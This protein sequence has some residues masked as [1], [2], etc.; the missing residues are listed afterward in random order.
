MKFLKSFILFA[1]FMICFNLLAFGSDQIFTESNIND[2]SAW[3]VLNNSAASVGTITGNFI[4]TSSKNI[5][6]DNITLRADTGWR[7]IISSD[8]GRFFTVSGGNSLTLDNLIFTRGIYD[9]SNLDGGGA[10]SSTGT[11]I[12]LNGNFSIEFASSSFLG[13]AIYVQYGTTTFN[14][15]SNF[16][17]NYAVSGHGGAIYSGGNVIFS[18]GS[19]VNLNDNY[20]GWNGGGIYSELG[21]VTVGGAAN[22][23]GNTAK[24]GRGG[25]IFSENGAYFTDSNATIYI[26]S[27]AAQDFGGGIYSGKDILFL[28]GA[29]IKLNNAMI[30]SSTNT[31]H[32]GG[33]LY[34]ASSVTFKNDTAVINLQNNSA[35]DS[36]GAIFSYSTIT[37]FGSA[38]IQSNKVEALSG[39][40]IWAGGDIIFNNSSATATISSNMSVEGSG[41]AFYCENDIVFNG[42]L[43][44][45]GNS[46]S[47]GSGGAFYS[48]TLMISDGAEISNNSA[49]I[50]GGAIYIYDGVS[51]FNALEKDILFTSNIAAS[52]KNDINLGGNA[53]LNLTALAAA[54]TFNG[55]ITYSTTT[56]NNVVN[57]YG[58]GTL[59][60]NGINNFQHLN[61]TSGTTI[62]GGG[63]VFE[64]VNFSLTGSDHF[65]ST[66]ATTVL[67]MRNNNL[68]DNLIIS[69]VLNSTTGAKIYFDIDS[70]TNASDKISAAQAN[71]EGTWIKV[72]I[73]G[74]DAYEKSYNIFYSTNASGTM[75]ID[76][77]N[78]EGKTMHRVNSHLEYFD[79]VVPSTT[80]PASWESVNLVLSIDQLNVINGLTKN[81]KKT[82]LALDKEYGM[83][84]GDLFDII[85]K[86]DTLPD[87]E[88]KKKALTSLS[89]HIFA[90]VITVP[91][92]NISKDGVFSRL[93]RSY[94]I[95]DDSLIK[96]NI[97]AQGY[98]ADN[99]YKGD[100][101]SPGDFSVSNSG[102]QA[103]FDTMKDDTQIFGLNVGYTDMNAQQNGDTVGITGYNIGAYGAFFFENNFELKLVLIGGRQ[104]YSASRKINYADIQRRADSEFSGYSINMSAELGY[105][106]FYRDN[107]YFR[108]LLGLD[109]SYV[110]TQEFTEQGAN[111]A[112]LTIY[113]GSYSKMNSS[114]GLQVNNGIDMRAKWYVE[115]K[116]NFL[117]AGTR[118]AFEGEF[119]NTSQPLEIVGIENDILSM[120]VSAGVLYDI[121]KNWS[122]YA[123]VNG[124]FVSSQSGVYG[125][126][127]VNYKFTT[128]YFDFYEK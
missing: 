26:S 55:G 88:S 1:F 35:R 96:R 54:I 36:G 44:A 99:K 75:R 12:I 119:K 4:F 40:A 101:N 86:L 124:M 59:F 15:S 34:A 102:M 31:F 82:A 118:A 17:M 110:T 9:G 60:L 63:S 41:G 42:Y 78:S 69:G 61:I 126:I 117:L 84:L 100:K 116:F 50:Q 64:A 72:G 74:I 25:G 33:G 28:G 7:T 91:S 70:N 5:T 90:N 76:N 19:S 120:T 38:N 71:M 92:L 58:Y 89:G 57:K 27:N 128:T 56:S 121:S 3:S 48:K 16:S 73:A 112:D 106:Y 6:A 21:S 53:D 104:N 97:W 87:I 81:Q 95:P 20:A 10:I 23:S 8:S 13:G 11:S 79:G 49:K 47:G 98:T 107:I 65:L 125:N 24:T 18:S 62:L 37:F 85:D 122:V 45:S 43:K 66:A 114:L 67:D 46:A 32:F 111:S 51:D 39:G 115:T 22:I 68:N 29:D 113:A 80:A 103:G 127:G 2:S 93:K 108:P 83:A 109:Y 123:N 30:D 77:T 105:D 52:I 14:G 94:F